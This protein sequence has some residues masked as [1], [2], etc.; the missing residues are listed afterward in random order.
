[1]ASTVPANIAGLL[2]RLQAQ[3]SA[4]ETYVDFGMP[5]ELPSE[6]ER[7]VLLDVDAYERGGGEQYREE[8]YGLP[9]VVEVYRDGK[10]EAK[11]EA[12]SRRWALIDEIDALLLATDFPAGYGSEDGEMAVEGAQLV[13][14]DKGWISTCRMLIPVIERGV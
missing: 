1:M 9:I 13:P 3:F 10:A 14:Y 5:A 6:H 11:L 8:S 4:A 2:A 7:I 12:H